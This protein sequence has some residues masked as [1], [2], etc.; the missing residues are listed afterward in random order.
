VLAHV[1]I[2]LPSDLASEH[3]TKALPPEAHRL[4]ANVDARIAGCAA[5]KGFR[6]A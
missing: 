2:A 6:T 3:R 1:R 4:M 5:R